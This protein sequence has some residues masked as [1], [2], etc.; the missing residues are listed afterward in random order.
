M[1]NIQDVS[2]T[3]PPSERAPLLPERQRALSYGGRHFSP[4]TLL[5]PLAIATRLTTTLPSTTLLGVVQS[6]ICRLWLA[7]NGNLPPDGQMS[8]ELCAVPE[9]EK[10][11]AA[12]ISAL[13]IFDGLG[14]ADTAEFYA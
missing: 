12:V 6:V 3:K 10:T 9:V 7:T 4:L 11:Y 1:A 5:I 8:E 13:L 2:S 14:G